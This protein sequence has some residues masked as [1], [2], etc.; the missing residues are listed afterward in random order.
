VQVEVFEKQSVF[1]FKLHEIFYLRACILLILY[2]NQWLEQICLNTLF[3][4]RCK[5]T[6]YKIPGRNHIHLQNYYIKQFRPQPPF[7]PCVYKTTNPVWR[8]HAISTVQS[9]VYFLYFVECDSEPSKR[10][11]LLL[12]WRRSTVVWSE[13]KGTTCFKYREKIKSNS[14]KK[15]FHLIY[16]NTAYCHWKWLFWCLSSFQWLAVK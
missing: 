14:F 1:F 10:C 8:V 9:L 15:D 4:V 5:H 16:L 2:L 3:T 11:L 13:I 12:W 7:L 6:A